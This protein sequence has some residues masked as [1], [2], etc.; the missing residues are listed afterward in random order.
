VLDDGRLAAEAGMRAEFDKRLAEETRKSFEGGRERGKQEGRQA[1]RD[2][3]A[4]AQAVATQLRTR[5]RQT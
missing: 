3:Q 1:E 5:R 2:A 4:A